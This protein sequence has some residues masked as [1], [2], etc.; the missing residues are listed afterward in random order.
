MRVFIRLPWHCL[1]YLFISSLVVA[2]QQEDTTPDTSG[3]LFKLLSKEVTGVDFVNTLEEQPVDY[4]H[5]HW[6]YVYTGGGVATGDIN[7]DGLPDLYFCGNRVADALYLNKGNMQFENITM[8]AGILQDGQWSSGVTMGDLNG[9]GFLDIYVCRTS[10]TLNSDFM[11]NRL[12]LNNGDNTFREEA[13]AMKLN[14]GGYSTQSTFLDYDKDGDLDIYLV[15]QPP[16][17]RLISRYQLDV[18]TMEETTTDRLFRNDGDVF[19]DVTR[20]AGLWNHGYGLNA[21]ATDLNDDGLTDI[22]V[23]NDFDEPDFM[24]IN[25]G[26]G[27]FVDEIKARTQHVSFYAMG[28]DVGDFNNDGLPDLAVVDMASSDHFRSKTNMGSMQPEVFWA[29]IDKGWQY[30]YMFNTLQVNNGNGSFSDVG[31]LSGISKTDWSWSILMADFDNDG[32]QDISVTN[33]IQRDIR[34]NDFLLKVKQMVSGGQNQFETLDLVKLVPSNPLPNYLYHNNGD[35]TFTNRAEEW[36]MGQPNFSHGAAAAD[37]DLDGDLD[38]V[39]NASNQDGAI[40]ENKWGNQQHY[41]RIRLTGNQKNRQALNTK[42]VIRYGQGQQQ[43]RELTLTRGYFSASEP[44]LH[45]G[46]G[47]HTV[48]D[49]LVLTWPDGSQTTLEHVEADQLLEVDYNSAPKTPKAPTATGTALF[50]EVNAPAFRHQENDFDDFNREILLPHKQSTNGPPLVAADVNADGLEDFFVGGALGQAGQLFLQQ[51]DGSF[52]PASSQPWAKEA[53]QEDV[54]ALFFDANGDQHPD[55]YIASGG[56]EWTPSS[57]NYADRLYLN[58]GKGHFERNPDALPR[59]YES[60][61][62]ITAGDYDGDGDLDLFVGGRL[63]PGKYPAPANSYILRNDDGLFTDVTREVAPE[64]NPLGLVTD[65]LFVD[66]DKDGHDDLIVVGEWMPITL[67]HNQSGIFVDQ[68]EAAGLLQTGGWWWSLAA[69]DVDQDGDLDIICGNLGKNAKFKASKEKPFLVYQSD[70]DENGT[71]DVVLA[72]YYNGEQVPVRGRE[73]SSE[74]MPFIADKFPTYGD[75]AT[76]S[77]EDIYSSDALQSAN[78]RE[79]HTF[80][81]T[82]FVNQ[83]NGQ[84]SPQYLPTQAQFSPVQDV[85]LKDLNKDGHL[86]AVLVG[87]LY[88]AEVETVRYD[89]GTGL[90]MLGDGQ[91]GFAPLSVQESGIFAP[92]DARRMVFAND[93]ALLISNNNGALQLFHLK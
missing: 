6:D 25:Q 19:T 81:S 30:Q 67:L 87:N 62:A 72:G 64:L 34:N 22:Y 10:P 17:G 55:L 44:V 60:G 20:A 11:R 47:E 86:D 29:N 83:G 77:L 2:C 56:S 43:F 41:L 27:T 38:F 54:G 36:G 84:F 42:A 73:C 40:Y 92:G 78:K 68:T 49:E 24:Y 48:V 7:N 57:V 52:K 18:P 69:G 58:N 12:Y 9:D 76:A 14:H 88:G 90:C 93:N 26:D 35:Y 85:Q 59:Q 71:N 91:G 39:L 33:G 21:V 63:V 53:G 61:Q 8:K 75:F 28:S 5:L 66:Y 4:N 50:R 45:F 89:A 16:N 15:N 46:L 31:Q 13:K 74:Q 1:I 3:P 23:S 79:V 51:P 65:A 80:S 37:L 70:F 82:L 32:R